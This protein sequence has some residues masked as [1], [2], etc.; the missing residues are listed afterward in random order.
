MVT[1]NSDEPLLAIDGV[2]LG[3]GVVDICKTRG[4]RVED[5]LSRR[6][7]AR[8]DTLREPASRVLG[9]MRDWIKT[10]AASTNGPRGIRS[11]GQTF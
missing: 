2:G 4:Y 3:A 11:C 9:L 6:Q 10:R 8:P 7:G 1:Y 5:V